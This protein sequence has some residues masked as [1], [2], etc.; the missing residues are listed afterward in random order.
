V[1]R[2][3]RVSECDLMNLLKVA[4]NKVFRWERDWCLRARSRSIIVFPA[5]VMKEGEALGS[6]IEIKNDNTPV[7]FEGGGEG[8]KTGFIV[9][10]LKLGDSVKLHRSCECLVRSNL[11][12]SH[13]FEIID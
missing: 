4:P 5:A 12:S 1:S 2:V 7:A 9:I 6:I 8:L 11:S 13:E 3:F 10:D